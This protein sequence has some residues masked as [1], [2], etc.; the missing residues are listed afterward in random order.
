MRFC[1]FVQTPA[2]T[3][4][5]PARHHPLPTLIY[6]RPPAIIADMDASGP[7]PRRWL[8]LRAALLL[9]LLMLAGCFV[10]WQ[11]TESRNRDQYLD[12]LINRG[13]CGS[14]GVLVDQW[15]T[16]WPFHNVERISAVALVDGRFTD[17]D[18][19][20]LRQVFPG[21]RIHHRSLFL[22][23]CRRLGPADLV[24]LPED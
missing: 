15:S 5:L 18:V 14:P 17:D 21:V 3:V 11:W 19:R 24:K 7:S 2:E 10:A 16:K 9:V 8:D 4:S 6:P 1:R 13:V 22:C 23:A 20:R 12:D